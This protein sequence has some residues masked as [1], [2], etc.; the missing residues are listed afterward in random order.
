MSMMQFE[1][2]SFISIVSLMTL[3]GI[4][5]GVSAVLSKKGIIKIGG[6]RVERSW[7]IFL[8]TFRKLI[9]TPLWLMGAILGIL[10][11]CVYLVALQNFELSV[12]KP[13]VNTN[14]AFTF[15]LAYIF[16]QER[17]KWSEW[18]GIVGIMIGMIFLGIITRGSTGIIELV[19]L[20][21]LL[22]ITIT[23]IIILGVLIITERVQNQEFFYSISAG[24]FYGLG[25]IFSKA[26]LILLSPIT[27]FSLLVLA[28]VMF[29]LTYIVAIV[30]QQFAFHNGR[31]SIVS[32]ITN[33]ISVL[34]PVLGAAFIFNEFFYFE[35]LLGLVCILL[36]ILLLRRTII[37]KNHFPPKNNLILDSF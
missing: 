23:G 22:P 36:G 12:V 14:L 20:I 21:G 13:L 15:L 5:G 34:I 37:I 1:I 28:T 29:S 11:F 30:S 7:R 19:P 10:G 2:G 16:F 4:L 3:Y 17:L 8:Q 27:N 32:P 35:K 18:A 25:A 9:S 6:L 33:S 26:I 31:L 24:I